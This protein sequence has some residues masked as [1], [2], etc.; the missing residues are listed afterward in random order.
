MIRTRNKRSL[1]AATAALVLT[2]LATACGGGGDHGD[3][4]HEEVVRHNN[5]GSAQM[6]RQEWSEAER[7]FRAGLALDD[8]DAVL[9]NNLA[10]ALVQQGRNDEAAAELRRAARIAPDDPHV[11]YNLGLLARNAG[12][13]ESAVEHFRAVAASDP[14]DVATQYNLAGALSRVDRADEAEGAYRAALRRNPTHVSSLYGLGRLLIA[15]GRRDEGAALIERSQE[16]RE[17]SG[18]DE[19]MGTQ[20]GEQ[21]P[22]AMVAAHPGGGLLAPE[23]PFA[24]SLVA[25]DAAPALDGAG[26]TLVGFHGPRDRLLPVTVRDGRF[27]AVGTPAVPLPDGSAALAATS[28]DVDGDGTIETVALVRRDAPVRSAAAV[29]IR[30]GDPD[31]D[32]RILIE[33]PPRELP[34]GDLAADVALVDLDHDG[35]LDLVW[36]WTS[37][38]AARCR[39]ADNDGAG[40]YAFPADERLTFAGPGPG[41]IAIAFADTDDDRDVDV[42]VGRADG[43]RLFSNQ[44]DGRFSEIAGTAGL[45]PVDGATGPFAI[46][47]LDKDDRIDVLVATDRGATWFRNRRGRFVDPVALPASGSGEAPGS[48]AV[49]DLDN[50]GFLDVATVG[51]DGGLRIRR[52]LGDGVWSAPTI[53]VPGGLTRIAAA[54]DDDA[55][56]DV[57]LWAAGPDGAVRIDNEGGNRRGWI[58]VDPVGVRDNGYGIGAKVTLLA[59]GLRQRFQVQ[60]PFPVHLGIGDRAAIDAVRVLW[61]GGVLQDELDPAANERFEVE[62][63]DRK[64]TSCPL[65]YA[66]RDGAWRF[67]TDFLGGCAIGYQYAPGRLSTPDTDEYVRID[68]GVTVEDGQVRLRLNN[69]LEEVIWFD[70]VELVAVDHP[71]G[72]MAYP[73]ERLMPG[74]P[75]PPFELFV[76][77][78]VLPPVQATGVESGEDVTDVLRERD[79]RYVDDFELLPYKGYA[80][81]HTLELDF[82]TVPAGERLVLLLDGWIDYADSSANV[83]AGHAGLVAEPPVL[84]FED[85]RGGWAPLDEHRMGF[86]AGLPKTM[87]V[88]LT[89]LFPQDRARLRIRTTLRIYWD[90]ARLMVGGADAPVGIH[91]R[92]PRRAELRFGGFPREVFPDGRKP[93]VYDPA[94]V[95]PTSP[96]KAHAGAYTAFGDVTGLLAAI[97]D[98]LV[99]TRSGDEIELTFD[100]PPAPAPGLART[101][102][103]YADGFGKD[104][105]PN[106]AANREVGPVPFH[107]MPTYPYGE[108]VRPPHPPAPSATRRVVERGDGLPGVVPLGGLDRDARGG[109]GR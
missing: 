89:G 84:L 18:I 82:G 87:A 43:V 104:M 66:W 63:L 32:A 33:T 24:P 102:L 28:G 13:F 11:R 26:P 58:E 70:Q 108:D 53:A 103:L 86:P 29:A 40:G 68:G 64:G 42:F 67:V 39:T 38:R 85:G 7:E 81:R 9:R 90:R 46:A 94:T 49:S 45:S 95:D 109:D 48:I 60:D 107:G 106:S 83:A 5:R 21:G 79:R 98:R 20:Y 31:A 35:D 50:D 61:P 37:P 44:R 17:R 59:G 23:G 41:P 54:F 73:N 80:R 12:D 52:G 96:W 19:A 2:T 105:D 8:D 51:A 91:R 27:V 4:V 76:S 69:Q 71:E 3:E 15:T 6:S 22:Y 47:D 10:V 36:C 100:A 92:A 16:I 55:D 74:P 57:D 62:Q 97:D 101:W 1:A 77:D 25:A 93:N 65:L 72:T 99:T 78:T 34:D 14:D 88:D 75:F 56:G 30:P